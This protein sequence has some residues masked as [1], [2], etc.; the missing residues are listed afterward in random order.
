MREKGAPC[1]EATN[2]CDLPEVCTGRSGQC[3]QDIYKKNGNRCE[4]NT[5]TCFN[6]ICPTLN[7]QCRLIW[8]DGSFV[9]IIYQPSSK[10]FDVKPCKTR[11]VTLLSFILDSLNFTEYHLTLPYLWSL[12]IIAPSCIAVYI[13]YLS[14][15]NV[16]WLLNQMI[17]NILF[18]NFYRRRG[19][20]Q[21]VFRSV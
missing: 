13:F 3:P 12:Y 15:N 16:T 17:E 6:G 1:R 7:S 9:F 19:W 5:G 21:E 10:F 8:G 11:Y 4:S 20:R 18:I 2:E 14:F